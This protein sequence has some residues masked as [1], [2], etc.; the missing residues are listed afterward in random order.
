MTDILARIDAA[1]EQNCACG[2]GRPLSPTGPSGYYATEGCQQR[3]LL[4][5]RDP[6]RARRRRER[7]AQ[8][9]HSGDDLQPMVERLRAGTPTEPDRQAIAESARQA[10]ILF[11]EIA[12]QIQPIMEVLGRAVNRFLAQTAA[13]HAAPGAAKAP[14]DA[15]E[16]A[17]AHVRNRN[18]GPQIRQPVPRRIDPRRVR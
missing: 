16:R 2:C 4:D 15:R 13:L 7:T 8:R 6:D 12:R 17:L 11:A 10:N 18:T 1:I 3:W 14:A 5:H 9:V